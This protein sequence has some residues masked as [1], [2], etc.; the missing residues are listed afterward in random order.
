MIFLCFVFP[1]QFS[2]SLSVCWC[3][4]IFHFGWSP[5]R[6][7]IKFKLHL[8]W[9]IMMAGAGA[10]WQVW[11]TSLH[12]GIEQW[13]CSARHLDLAMSRHNVSSC[14]MR[15]VSRCS[16][17]DTMPLKYSRWALIVILHFS[18]SSLVY[19]LILCPSL[20]GVFVFSVSSG[21]CISALQHY[22]FRECQHRIT[23]SLLCLIPHRIRGLQPSPV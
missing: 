6:P 5:N 8:W 21:R 13:I 12:N 18:P 1:E 23:N 7:Y 9:F 19:D 16:Y 14:Q 20:A 2:L 3:E 17:A 10:P 22:L 4:A 15:Q 11:W